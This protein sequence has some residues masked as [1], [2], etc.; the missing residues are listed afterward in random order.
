MKAI[1]LVC[2]AA[3]FVGV[4]AADFCFGQLL[5]RGYTVAPED[6]KREGRPAWWTWRPAEMVAPAW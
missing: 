3:F 1:A 6:W 5:K 2:S 4:V